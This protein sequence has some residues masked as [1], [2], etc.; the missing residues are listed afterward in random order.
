MEILIVGIAGPVFDAVQAAIKAAC[1]PGSWR[2]VNHLTPELAAQA[3]QGEMRV[4]ATF[5]P[6]GAGDYRTIAA[7]LYAMADLHAATPA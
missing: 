6:P 3:R 5:D 4:I 2:A 7:A 1:A